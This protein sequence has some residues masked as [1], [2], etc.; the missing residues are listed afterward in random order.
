MIKRFCS[1]FGLIFCMFFLP[2]ESAFSQSDQAAL[3]E[4]SQACFRLR[5]RVICQKALIMAEALQVKAESKKKFA[6]QT[7]ALGLGSE[8]IMA[9]MQVNRGYQSQQI[10]EEVIYLCN[11]F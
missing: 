3:S 4:L 6:C 10:L 11:D 1:G 9:Q 2:K 8:L 5:E 7:M